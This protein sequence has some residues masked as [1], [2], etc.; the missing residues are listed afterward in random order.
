MF[1]F[2][3]LLQCNNVHGSSQRGDHYPHPELSPQEPADTHNAV[4]G[5][6]A[7]TGT[8]HNYSHFTK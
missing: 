1:F 3:D 8:R 6:T 2:S 4:L 7:K 5:E